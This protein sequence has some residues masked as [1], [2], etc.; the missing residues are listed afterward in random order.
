MH[1]IAKCGGDPLFTELGDDITCLT[2]QELRQHNVTVDE[3]EALRSVVTVIFPWH[4]R[5]DKLR[6]GMNRRINV[7]PWMIVYANNI[8][9]VQYA[10]EFATKYK[11][12]IA[13]RSGGHCIENFSTVRGMI[14]DQSLRKDIKI[15]E[16]KHGTIAKLNAGVLL[17]PLAYELSLDGLVL[18]AGTCDNVCV[19]GLTLG[20]GIGFLGRKFGLTCDN[21]LEVKLVLADG[22]SVKASAKKNADL[23]WACRGGGG[24]NF[25]IVTEFKFRLEHLQHVWLFELKYPLKCFDRVFKIWQSWAPFTHRGMTAKVTVYNHHIAVHGEYVHEHHGPAIEMANELIKIFDPVASSLMEQPKIWK[26]KYVDAVR[27]FAGNGR[28]LP[29]VKSFNAFVYDK[30]NR[31]ARNIV[32]AHSELASEHS[33]T[34]FYAFGGAI[35]DVGDHETAFAHRKALYWMTTTAQ[36]VE[37][38]A[39]NAEL[40]WLRDY[41]ADIKHHTKGA[42]VNIPYSEFKDAATLYYGHNL[43]RLRSI[44]KE[45]DPDNVFNYS[46]SIV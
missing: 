21:V 31:K 8:Q 4:S 25:G 15:R 43:P 3:L 39:E 41:Y 2:L 29:Y 32:V 45:Y 35:A 16:T 38:T 28:W 9:D 20:G 24:G 44:K 18:P 7:F 19:S 37:Q 33:G 14:I 1:A 46:Q 10:L 26:S 12:P 23:F 13:V 17:G 40:S 42:Y 34:R 27:F 36:W 11:I 6:F 22:R 30:L 5:Y